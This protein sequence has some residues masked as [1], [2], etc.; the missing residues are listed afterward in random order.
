MKKNKSSALTIFCF[1]SILMVPPVFS[2]TNDKIFGAVYR[3][4]G[5][6]SSEQAQ[7]IYYNPVN[8]LD[9]AVAYVYVDDEYEAA[10]IPGM[11]T[12][13][14]VTPG[15][16]TMGGWRNDA[17]LYKGKRE[18]HYRAELK[19]GKTYFVRVDDKI[20]GQPFPVRRHTAEEELSHTRN[21]KHTLSR[22][23]STQKCLF[24]EKPFID[25]ALSSDVLFTFGR[26]GKA[27]I[28][29]AGHQAISDLIKKLQRED[30]HKNNILVIGHADLLGDKRSNMLLGEKRARTVADL[31]I[32]GGLSEASISIQSAGS[33]EPVIGSCQGDLQTRI[34][35]N[36][37]NRRVVVRVETNN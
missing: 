14:C 20:N 26:S 37:P 18:I 31:L 24:I 2:V 23:S 21:Q 7:V 8:A 30:I 3:S 10:L 6:I 36:T 9:D 29:Q 5:T 11:Y 13:F 17:P 22:A 34:A 19:G 1:S 16:H 28:Q 33:N 12:R 27:D 15:S 25:Y 4:A 35:C 32:A